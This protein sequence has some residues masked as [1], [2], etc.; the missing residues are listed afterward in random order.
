MKKA[1]KRGQNQACLSYA[2]RELFGATLKR[3]YMKP[4]MREVEI[5]HQHIICTS[6]NGYNG[7]SLG[8]YRDSGDK[9]TDSDEGDIF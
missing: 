9:I 3:Q 2:E 8:T 7:Q 5:R 4:A 1:I 6:P